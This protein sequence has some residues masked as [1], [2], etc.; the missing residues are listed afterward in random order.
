[1]NNLY[2]LDTY[3]LIEISYGNEKFSKYIKEG[4]VISDWTLGEFFYVWMQKYSEEEADI[5]IK[6]IESCSVSVSKEIIIKAMKF[7]YHHKKINK[8]SNISFFDA[9]GYI[10]SK[11]N[12]CL[13]VTG[14]KEFEN[15]DDVEYVKK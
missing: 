12:N 11:E 2:C 14:D 13:F 9:V 15:L 8:T 4:F 5:L 6:Q 3:A 10:F 1:M 7:R